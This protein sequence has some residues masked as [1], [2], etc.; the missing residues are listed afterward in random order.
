[1]PAMV[2]V[3]GGGLVVFAAVIAYAMTRRYGW[4]AALALPVLGLI[5]M[6]AMQWQDQGLT[7]AEGLSMAGTALIF[8]APVLLGFAAGMMVAWLRR[9]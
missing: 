7:V 2:W 1:M 5:A 8:S 4:G 9:S 3:M 6:I